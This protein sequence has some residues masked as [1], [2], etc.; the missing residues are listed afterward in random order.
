MKTPKKSS[1]KASSASQRTQN[2]WNTRKAK[3]AQQ[4]QRIK[5]LANENLKLYDKI[6]KLENPVL[7]KKETTAEQLKRE[8]EEIENDFTEKLKLHQAE[9]ERI[10]N[11]WNAHSEE[12][13][14]MDE[15]KKAA[16]LEIERKIEY[17]NIDLKLEAKINQRF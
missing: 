14:K 10:N 2:A 9:W 8:K 4:E 7:S 15:E 16:I 6:H 1:A 11:L 13:K 3:Q 5:D 17:H 12:R